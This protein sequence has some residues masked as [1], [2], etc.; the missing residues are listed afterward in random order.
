MLAGAAA[1][2]T[3]VRH[4]HDIVNSEMAEQIVTSKFVNKF[5]LSFLD[6]FTR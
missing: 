4:T 2:V 6:H 3:R 1:H 5:L